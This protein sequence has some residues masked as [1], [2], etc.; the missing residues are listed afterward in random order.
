MAGIV[1]TV[2]C[3]KIS[4]WASFHDA[5]AEAFGFPSFYGRNMDAWIDCMSA[6]DSPRDGLTSINCNPGEVVTL[7]LENVN[8]LIANERQIY[9]ALIECAAFVNLRRI[10]LGLSAVVAFAF[11]AH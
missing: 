9:D 1:V 11:D 3:S 4:N 10:G 2:D 5:F 8:V 6:L 7:V